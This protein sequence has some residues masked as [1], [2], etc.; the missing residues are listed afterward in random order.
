MI[1]D[2]LN[3][4]DN[5]TNNSRITIINSGVYLVSFNIICNPAVCTFSLL[6]NGVTTVLNGVYGYYNNP[7]RTLNLVATNY[8]EVI[9]TNTHSVNSGVIE[10]AVSEK[11]MFQ[12]I[13][14]G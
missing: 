11:P 12:V 14:V 4:H 7:S 8:L 10:Y 3:M 1:F 9:A 6:I 2:P 13:K 5:V